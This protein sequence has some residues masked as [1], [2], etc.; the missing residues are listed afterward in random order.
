VGVRCGCL[1][2]KGPPEEILTVDVIK[3]VYKT[4]AIIKEDPI[5]S[6]PHIFLISNC[7]KADKGR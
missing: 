4:K 3:N 1:Y 6:R 2:K 7:Q 5:S